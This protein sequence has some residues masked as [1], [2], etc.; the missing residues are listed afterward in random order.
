VHIEF[1]SLVGLIDGKLNEEEQQAL[2]ELHQ[3]MLQDEGS[4]ALGDGFLAFVG[5][6]LNSSSLIKQWNT[7]YKSN[8]RKGG[9]LF[10]DIP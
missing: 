3:Y 4:W 2:E 7:F 6:I 10:D 1:D 5:M 8:S 9:S